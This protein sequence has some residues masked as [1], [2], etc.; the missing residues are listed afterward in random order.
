MSSWAIS[1]AC[2]SP[3]IRLVFFS[4]SLPLSPPPCS[5]LI[6]VC[7]TSSCRVVYFIL[8]TRFPPPWRRC[9]RRRSPWPIRAGITVPSPV[10][11]CRNCWR[12]MVTSWFE[13]A[14]ANRNMCCLCTGAAS[15]GTSSFRVQKWVGL[16]SDICASTWCVQGLTIKPFYACLCV[17]L[18][19][20]S[21]WRWRLHLCT[22]ANKAA[23]QFPS[24]R[25]E[26]DRHCA[27]ETHR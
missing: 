20:V 25:H 24:S 16:M 17:C 3:S 1:A 6:A 27:E 15:A 10:W 7:A 12:M 4:V 21:S 8:L 13:K 11:R 26:E 5:L 14:R 9:P 22:A 23:H 18:G 19:C 2:S